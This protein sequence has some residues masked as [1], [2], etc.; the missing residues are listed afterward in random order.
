[1]KMKG[2]SMDKNLTKQENNES[3]DDLLLCCGCGELFPESK[4]IEIEDGLYSC[5]PECSKF[6]YSMQD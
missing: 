5:S 6:Y 3:E 4:L 2:F 1:M